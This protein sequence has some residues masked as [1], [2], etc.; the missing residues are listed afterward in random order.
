MWQVY[1]LAGMD[2]VMWDG[3]PPLAV[4]TGLSCYYDFGNGPAPESVKDETG[5]YRQVAAFFLGQPQDMWRHYLVPQK[6][7]E[8][9]VGPLFAL[10][11]CDSAK[12]MA[13]TACRSAGPASL[14]AH[15][16]KRHP[17]TRRS[18]P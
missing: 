13:G 14:S 7:N 8:A 5:H 9:H 17:A 6:A 11:V 3:E 1:V 16:Y 15:H 18:R 12:T 4:I 2:Y 10:Q